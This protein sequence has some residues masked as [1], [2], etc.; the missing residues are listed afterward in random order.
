MMTPS[1]RRGFTLIEVLFAMVIVGIIGIA[2][3]RL[4]SSQTRFFDHE[5]NLRTARTISRSS[6][7][8]LLA[9]LRMVQ[10]SGGVDSVLADG[11]L[12]RAF[13]PYRV[14]LVCAT[15]G[16][17]TTVSMLPTDSATIA[18]SVYSGFAW[19]NAA[20]GRYTY[21]SPANPNTS[22]APVAAADPTLCTG[23]GNGQA[24]IRTVSAS[25]RAGDV[26]DVTNSGGSGAPVG[27]PVFFWQRITYSFRASSIYPGRNALWR[28][29]QGGANEELMSPF[30]TSA[31]FKFYQTGEDTARSA[32]PPLSDIRGL[33]LVLTAISPRATSRDSV[34]SRSQLSTAVFFKNVRSY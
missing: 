23:T 1:L 10:D 18:L 12:V 5:T 32:P 6:T 2:A 31:R 11:S 34:A 26:L 17:R 4:L 20:T 25:G 7:N 28:N 30:D 33:Q 3:T 8:V 27:A 14:G 19:R 13:V 29:V 9:D 15:A 16:N 24:Q 22:D 21:V